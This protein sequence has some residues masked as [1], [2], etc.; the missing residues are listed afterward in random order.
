VRRA[1]GLCA[2]LAVG[3]PAMAAGVGPETKLPLPRYVSLNASKINVRRGPGLDYRIDWVYRR[4]GLPVRVVDEFGHWRRIA[5]SEGDEGWVYHALLSGRRTVVVV[6][7]GAVL[8]RRPE[9][10]AITGPCDG[11]ALPRGAVACAE[12]G[13]VAALSACRTQWC[14]VSAGGHDGWAPKSALWG[15]DATEVFGE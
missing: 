11:A 14:R 7:E 10:A 3:L 5:D 13:V 9:G 12:R 8:T 6:A 2:A 1:V 4:S 15:V